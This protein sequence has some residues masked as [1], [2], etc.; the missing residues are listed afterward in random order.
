[1][2]QFRDIGLLRLKKNTGWSE[3][4]LSG[5]LKFYSITEMTLNAL[6]Y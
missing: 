3:Q 1:M 2:S 4:S 6:A 5:A